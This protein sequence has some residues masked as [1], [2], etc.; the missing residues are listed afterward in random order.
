MVERRN[1]HRVLSRISPHSRQ[2]ENRG[3]HERNIRKPKFMQQ[4]SS[5]WTV[6]LGMRHTSAFV[7]MVKSI[8][9]T[10]KAEESFSVKLKLS[11]YTRTGALG[12]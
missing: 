9:V 4:G 3:V 6:Q 5:V 8:R 2:P 11:A 12:T 10:N 1:E 7:N